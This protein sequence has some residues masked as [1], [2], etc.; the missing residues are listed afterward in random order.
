MSTCKVD[1][2]KNELEEKNILIRTLI[3]KETDVY[4]YSVIHTEISSMSN[5]NS[6]HQNMEDSKDY[7]ME[8]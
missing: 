4:N 8:S 3:I 7:S 5:S 6:V 1:F 2:V